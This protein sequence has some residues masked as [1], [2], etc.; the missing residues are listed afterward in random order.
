MAELGNSILN[1]QGEICALGAALLWAVASLWFK[2]V[3]KSIKPIEL[4]LIKGVTGLVLF[5]ATSLLLGETFRSM[6]G[7]VL[8]ALIISGAVG[9]G[10]GDTMFFKAINR[11]GSSRTLLISTLAPPLAAIFGWIFLRENLSV[12]AWLGILVTVFGVTWVVTEKDAGEKEENNK[13]DWLGVFFG[14]L[15][16]LTQA[17]GAVLS[18]W[19]LVDTAIS[20]LQSAVIREVGGVAFLVF[21]IL[22][23]REAIGQWI[24]ARPEGRFWVTLA[25]ILLL[26]TYCAIWLQQLAFQFSPVGIASTLL[27]T[28]PLFVLPFASRQKE[29]LSPRS[30]LGVVISVIG[31]GLIFLVN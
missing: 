10:F 27:A 22:I 7:L 23:K 25:A 4:N 18:R 12:F 30:I 8:A 21:W 11:L 28:S 15:A 17:A 9:I 29:K 26:G 31:I 6:S 20:A 1:F 3:G 5:T 16:A 2:T 13:I 24:K 19:A 14:F